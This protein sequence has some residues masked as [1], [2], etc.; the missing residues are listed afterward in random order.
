M[1]LTRNAVRLVL[2]LIAFL[3]HFAQSHQFFNPLLL[4]YCAKGH[5]NVM[6]QLTRNPQ[7]A[8]RDCGPT[9][10]APPLP[11]KHL[12]NLLIFI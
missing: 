7:L 3:T 5:K 11:L 10:P 1:V 6:S 8:T 2:S 9:H 4:A 12:K